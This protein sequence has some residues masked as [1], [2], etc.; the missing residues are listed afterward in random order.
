LW[1][2]G[3]TGADL[4]GIDLS[5]VG[6]DLAR[7]QATR[8]GLADRARFQ[9]GDLT[10]TGLPDASCDAVLSLDVWPSCRTRPLRPGNLRASFG[11]V[12]SWDS[13]AGNK[14][15]TPHDLAQNS[16]RT[17]A[18]YWTRRVSQLRPTTSHR[19][20][21]G[22]IARLRKGSSRLN[23]RC[24]GKWRWRS[25]RGGRRWVVVCWLICRCGAMSEL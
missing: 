7:E 2:S 4:I 23:T 8:L 6:V 22:T 14:W 9:V 17:I 10:N 24:P 21:N 16:A 1:I 25:L 12:A 13:Q 5:P 3:R 18:L 15:D 20:G 11:A 19:N